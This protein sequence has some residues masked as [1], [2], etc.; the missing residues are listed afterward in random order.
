MRK[1]IK[2]RRNAANR[3]NSSNHSSSTS[4]PARTKRKFK[5]IDRIIDFVGI[6]DDSDMKEAYRAMFGQARPLDDLVAS[7]LGETNKI[8]MAL[9]TDLKR[10]C[11]TDSFEVGIQ[12]RRI[13]VAPGSAV[14]VDI[15]SARKAVRLPKDDGVGA[16]AAI[17]LY[18]VPHNSDPR[19]FGIAV[20]TVTV[21]FGTN[22]RSAVTRAE[23]KARSRN[24]VRQMYST[25]IWLDPNDDDALKNA[26]NQ[27]LRPRFADQAKSQ[28]TSLISL[29]EGWK[30][31]EARALRELVMLQ[32]L[33]MLPLKKKLIVVG[34]GR[35]L[36]TRALASAEHRMSEVCKGTTS[37]I[38]R[39]G[40]PH[41]WFGESRRLGLDDVSVPL[42][43][44]H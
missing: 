14:E 21:F 34:A 42:I 36:L 22:A 37:A 44:L 6:S 2:P 8:S 18:P 4:E 32:C 35:P 41:F 20:D 3:S 39:D 23:A 43:K 12:V 26:L 19:G 16:I 30:D 28:E 40:V 17:Q 24:S 13:R 29:P 7:N 9:M 27:L 1:P 38:H 10:K 33:S 25:S 31:D 11:T 5:P 15:P